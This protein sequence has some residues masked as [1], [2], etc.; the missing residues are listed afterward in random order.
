MMASYILS[1]KYRPLTALLNGADRAVCGSGPLRPD[2]KKLPEGRL[3]RSC[4]VNVGRA[5]TNMYM[6]YCYG[7]YERVGLDALPE[8]CAGRLVRV[9]SYGDPAAVPFDL[10]TAMLAKAEGWTGYTHDWP[11][12]RSQALKTI[13]QASVDSD[14]AEAKARDLGWATFRLRKAGDAT[15]T[16]GQILCPASEEAGKTTTDR[17]GKHSSKTA[18]CNER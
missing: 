9:G 4:Y 2:P 18:I 14:A 5:P 7:H 6:A 1:A 3:V 12:K 17:I 10:W 11:H 13:C 16:K 15:V 8:L